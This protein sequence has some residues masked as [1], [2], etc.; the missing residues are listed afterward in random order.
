MVGMPLKAGQ[1]FL[2]T[3]RTVHGSPANTTNRRRCGLA[4]RI[5]SADATIYPGGQQVDGNGYRLD[6]Y[7]AILC[8]GGGDYQRNARL[9]SR[10]EYRRHFLKTK[11]KGQAGGA[12]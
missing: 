3:E 12:S 1:F 8:H 9:V 6:R 5:T 7:H 2:F 11:A 10:E 4:G